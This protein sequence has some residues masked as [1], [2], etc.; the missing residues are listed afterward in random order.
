MYLTVVVDDGIERTAFRDGQLLL[1]VDVTHL[2]R[3]SGWLSWVIWSASS[4]SSSSNSALEV[5][6]WIDL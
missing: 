4:S 1:G 6:R 3:V 5:R 2:G